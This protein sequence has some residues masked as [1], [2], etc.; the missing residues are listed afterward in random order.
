MTSHPRRSRL[1][2]WSVD[3]ATCIATHGPTGLRVRFERCPTGGWDGA[4]VEPIPQPIVD[5]AIQDGGRECARL[6]REAGDAYHAY[7]T[8]RQ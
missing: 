7:L 5:R 1:S 8:A 3:P 2:R 4:P 6:M